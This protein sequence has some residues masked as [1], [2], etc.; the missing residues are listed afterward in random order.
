[1]NKKIIVLLGMC[2][3]AA[4]TAAANEV[5]LY[6]GGYVGQATKEVPRAPYD[7]L[8][9]LIQQLALFTPVEDRIS[10]D[11]TDTAFGITMGYR[12]NRFLALEAGYTK[13]GTVSYKSRATGDY[14]FDSGFLNTTV[15][16]QTSGFTATVLGVW[17]LTRDWELFARAGML[18]A[19]NRLRLSFDAQGE[20]FIPAIGNRASDSFSK[21]TTDTYAGVGISRRILEIYELRLEYHRVFDG[22]EEITG[23]KGDLDAALLGLTVTF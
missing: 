23:G 3:A 10:F 7:E 13:L 1:M 15:E 6:I 21:S 22:G 8:N 5:G 16:S 14:P 2:A 17:R 20:E 12:L 9:D 18:F 19:T 4:Q 11:D